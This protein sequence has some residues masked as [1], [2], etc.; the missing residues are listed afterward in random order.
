MKKTIQKPLITEFVALITRGIE[1][2]HKA[3][4]VV[5]QLID[6]HGLTISDIAETSEFLTED[7]VTRFE[8]LGRK[9]LDPRLLV[10][11]YPAARYLVRLPFSEQK[12]AMASSVDLLVIEGKATSM[13]KVSV[14]NL[15]PS[16]CKQVFDGDQIRTSGAQRAWLEDR[17]TTVEVRAALSSPDDLYK[18]IGKKVV[19]KR[20]C[21]MSAG[22]LARIISEIE[23]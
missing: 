6:E 8:Q 20:A 10:A 22:Q 19:F 5:V 1:C 3:G 12:R 18:V 23:K 14:E 16:Q 2:W 11:G 9:Q 21:E 4:E 17:K 7:I 15:T 13:L